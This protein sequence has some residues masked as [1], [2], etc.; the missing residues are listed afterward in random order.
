MEY[1]DVAEYEEND[2][3]LAKHTIATLHADIEETR[4]CVEWWHNRWEAEY[5]M[6]ID[7][8]KKVEELTKQ[9]EEVLNLIED[10]DDE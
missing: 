5:K 9:V 3:S 10:N 4:V 1:E 7:L 2:S 6:R 8:Q